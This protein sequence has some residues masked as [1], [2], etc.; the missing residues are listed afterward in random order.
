MLKRLGRRLLDLIDSVP[1]GWLAPSRQP[2]PVRIRR[3]RGPFAR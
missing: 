1:L 2:V 3:Y